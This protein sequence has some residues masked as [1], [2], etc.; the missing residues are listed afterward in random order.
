MESQIIAWIFALILA[1][2]L[3]FATGT[4]AHPS[5][6]FAAVW[7]VFLAIPTFFI[8][9]V[10]PAPTTAW[11]IVAAI[12]LVSIGAP[13][14]VRAGAEHPSKI[15]ASKWAGRFVWIGGIAA[16][17]SALVTQNAN[18]VSIAQ[19]FSWDAINNAAR[20]LTVMRYDGHVTTP[21]IATILLALTYAAA[22]VGP[23]TA[24]S[25]H[26][27]RRVLL[28]IVPALGGVTYAALT[29]ARA[30]FIIILAITIAAW[31]MARAVTEG[32]RPKLPARTII[33]GLIAAAAAA[34]VFVW[35]AASR[36]GGFDT[37]TARTLGQSAGLYAGGSIP[38]F[39]AWQP[40][41]IAPNFGAQTFA[42]FAQFILGDRGIGA[43]YKDFTP[44]GVGLN[45]NVY[46]ALRPLTEDFTVPGMLIALGV[47]AAIGAY[48]Y[49]RAIVRRS[50]L[51]AA[52]AVTWGA[53]ALFSQTTSIYTF[54]NVTAGIL[55][56]MVL[57]WRLVKFQPPDAQLPA[58]ATRAVLNGVQ[59]RAPDQT[60]PLPMKNS[61]TPFTGFASNNCNAPPTYGR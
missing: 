11:L 21:T 8:E 36:T 29:T 5:T 24:V 55:I 47:A 51:A 57:I 59:N 35:V 19:V 31:L 33:L 26:G 20:Q 4:W 34:G 30:P 44:I 13:L 9:G 45:T 16:G 56:A 12:V 40:G 28:L 60:N 43:A 50:A 61:E 18:G 39:D 3:R 49:R 15:S 17:A 52:V 10:N 7:V 22:M 48:A 54:A 37:T 42:G 46:T 53:F 32:G 38:A 23:F 6:L 25:T 41:N 1:F 14:G 2:V 58:A 27:L